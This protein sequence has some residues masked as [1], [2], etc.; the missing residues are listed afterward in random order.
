MQLIWLVWM[1][2]LIL[3]LRFKLRIV[4]M[5]LQGVGFG[6]IRYVLSV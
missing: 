2:S 1:L 3:L 5:I 6:L 4:P